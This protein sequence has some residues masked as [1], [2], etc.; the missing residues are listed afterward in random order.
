MHHIIWE[1]PADSVRY[2]EC[3]GIW[4]S[5]YTGLAGVS[6]EVI[7]SIIHWPV[8]VLTDPLNSGAVYTLDF[9]GVSGHRS[10]KNRSDHKPADGPTASPPTRRYRRPSTKCITNVVSGLGEGTGPSITAR[11]SDSVVSKCL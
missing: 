1:R 2:N 4:S 11:P 6:G 10:I 7:T 8:Q 5:I 9:W 3:C